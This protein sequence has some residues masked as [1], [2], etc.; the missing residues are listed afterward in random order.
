M[1]P[2]RSIGGI[3]LLTALSV[4]LAGCGS[5]SSSSS[6]QPTSQTFAPPST[7]APVYSDAQAC[8]AFHDAITTGIPASVDATLPIGTTTLEWLQ[9]QDGNADPTLQG[10][11][12]NFVNAWN[13]PADTT[14]INQAQAAVT[15]W[16]SNH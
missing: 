5:S 10:L 11:I 3:L 4:I 12:N 2:G 9:S 15:K 6:F 14:A 7:T 16:C 1:N 13:N 8:Q